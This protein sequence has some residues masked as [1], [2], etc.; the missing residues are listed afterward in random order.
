[1]NRRKDLRDKPDSDQRTLSGPSEA[2][3][4]GQSIDSAEYAA[5]ET[6]ESNTT[7]N[8]NDDNLQEREE[9]KENTAATSPT[10]NGTNDKDKQ[11]VEEAVIKIQALFRGHLTRKAL[12]DAHQQSVPPAN[13]LGQSQFDED[14]LIR[15]RKY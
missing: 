8:N 3:A 15:N 9:N 14:S 7:N 13:A 11:D 12:K 10:A 5:L 4:V 6:N 2:I 1:M